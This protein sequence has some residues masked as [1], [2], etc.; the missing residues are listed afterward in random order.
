MMSL[1]I[2][3]RGAAR[4]TV[5]TFLA[6]AAS[7]VLGCGCGPLTIGSSTDGDAGTAASGG[8]KTGGGSSVTGAGVA[9]DGGGTIAGDPCTAGTDY[10]TVEK[11][12]D[13][14]RA[15]IDRVSGILRADVGLQLCVDRCRARAIG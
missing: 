11:G 13:P 1:S 7:A 9:D 10:D 12:R 2:Y 6:L 5:A 8:G 3:A 15:S 14:A 4:P